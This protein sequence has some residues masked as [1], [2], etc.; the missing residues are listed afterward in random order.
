MKKKPYF[1]NKKIWNQKIIKFE[2]EELKYSGQIFRI[3]DLLFKGINSSLEYI[4][5]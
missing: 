1:K 3:K 2:K 4:L 5:F